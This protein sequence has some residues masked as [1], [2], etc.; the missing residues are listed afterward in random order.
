MKPRDA[1]ESSERGQG[2][3]GAT[4]ARLSRDEA[5]A[6]LDDIL[7]E[8]P[9]TPVRRWQLSRWRMIEL[10]E[11]QPQLLDA[12]F[13][14]RFPSQAYERLRR[15]LRSGAKPPDLAAFSDAL[16]RAR[17]GNRS[18]LGDVRAY[19]ERADV[20]SSVAK[21]LE[22]D[23]ELPQNRPIP[24]S[25]LAGNPRRAGRENSELPKSRNITGS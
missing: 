9:V 3:D 19:L 10:F 24:Q 23:R 13:A 16:R 22:D 5:H 7:Q 21:A 11:L 14:D 8:P 20:R 17:Q 4:V 25:S 18:A 12:H 1:V 6:L 15:A 2:V